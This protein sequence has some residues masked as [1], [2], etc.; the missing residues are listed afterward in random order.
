MPSSYS[1]NEPALWSECQ[2]HHQ[3]PVLVVLALWSL[4]P[5]VLP[6]WFYL[7]TFSDQNPQLVIFSFSQL[8]SP[9]H[10]LIIYY[11]AALCK[12]YCS[13]LLLPQSRLVQQALLPPH[14][15]HL[16]YQSDVEF[17]ILFQWKGSK[18]DKTRLFEKIFL[19]EQSCKIMKQYRKVS[20]EEFQVN[21]TPNLKK[22]GVVRC[23]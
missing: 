5:V 16:C 14:S 22:E 8:L 11:L 15:I 7:N 13:L 18:S 21:Q 1:D 17:S 23:L 3:R 20:L 4:R 2:D 6:T 19:L 10:L 12:F 9:S